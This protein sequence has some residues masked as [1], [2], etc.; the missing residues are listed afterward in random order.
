LFKRYHLAKAIAEKKMTVVYERSLCVAREVF[1][2]HSAH[3]LDPA[4]LYILRNMSMVG[5]QT[6]ETAL[7]KVY[8]T[9]DDVVIL[10]RIRRRDRPAER[11]ISDQFLLDLKHRM[12]KWA[13]ETNLRVI[14]TTR[15]SVEDVAL[16]VLECFEGDYSFS[17][18]L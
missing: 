3:L 17:K 6:F 16:K 8:L 14:D 13:H 18:W 11:P 12:D 15:M 9:A 4:D 7:K 5:E 2:Q 10:D 1:I